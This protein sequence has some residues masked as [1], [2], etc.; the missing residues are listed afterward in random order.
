ME[1]KPKYDTLLYYKNHPQ[2]RR[3]IVHIDMD[4]YFVSVAISVVC[5]SNPNSTTSTS[6]ISSSNYYM[7]RKYGITSIKIISRFNCITI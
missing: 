2:N 6:E 1:I 7:A 4:C 3:N 5:H